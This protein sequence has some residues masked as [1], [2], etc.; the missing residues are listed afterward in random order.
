MCVLRILTAYFSVSEISRSK[1]REILLV[2]NLAAV[3]ANDSVK[4]KMKTP[5][6]R[7]E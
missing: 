5:K 7:E 6:S 4:S 3:E 2:N 1:K